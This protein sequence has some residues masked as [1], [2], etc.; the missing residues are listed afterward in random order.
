MEGIFG[1]YLG[2]VISTIGAALA[3]TL[4][5]IGS[6]KGVGMA[7]QASAGVVSENPELFGRAL[8]LQA[9]PGTQGIYGLLVAF[10]ILLNNGVI[11][12]LDTPISVAQGLIYFMGALPIAF[13]GYSSA[14]AQ[15]KTAV[16]GI[17]LLGKK[18]EESGKA[19]TMAIMVETYAVLALLVSM[20][21]V[22]LGKA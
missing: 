1:G 9:L 7:G 21:T 11:S 20:L 3:A 5:G 6:A 22:L 16:A 13:V 4:A 2:L 15:G 17:G 12:A 14:I 18:P 19:I 10:L 8:V